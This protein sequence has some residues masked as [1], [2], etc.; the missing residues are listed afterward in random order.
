MSKKKKPSAFDGILAGAK[1]ALAVARGASNRSAYRV[2]ATES[3]DAKLTP[4]QE[5]TRT[6]RHRATEERR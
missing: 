5:K 4:V 1:E 6:Q 2:H 3:P